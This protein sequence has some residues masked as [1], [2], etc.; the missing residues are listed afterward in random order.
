MSKFPVIFKFKFVDKNDRIFN[1]IIV[2]GELRNDRKQNHVAS[3]PY[4]SKFTKPRRQHQLQRNVVLVSELKI[5][6]ISC[7]SLESASL[8]RL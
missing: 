3:L 1:K 5:Q 8:E 7:F 4:N 6:K 2:S